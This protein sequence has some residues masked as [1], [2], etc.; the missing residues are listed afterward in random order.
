MHLDNKGYSMD[1]KCQLQG[2]KWGTQNAGLGINKVQL[3]TALLY[4]YI[5]I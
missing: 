1:V 3:K 2:S 5:Q 4:I